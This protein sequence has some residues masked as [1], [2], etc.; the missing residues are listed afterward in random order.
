M[1][2]RGQCAR[3]A[4]QMNYEEGENVLLRCLSHLVFDIYYALSYWIDGG[5][6]VLGEAKSPKVFDE[7]VGELMRQMGDGSPTQLC[8]DS[9]QNQLRRLQAHLGQGSCRCICQSSPVGVMSSLPLDWVS[10][11]RHSA[12]RPLGNRLQRTRLYYCLHS[13]DTRK[14]TI[15]LLAGFILLPST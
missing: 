5:L 13:S 2:L 10:C 4:F 11:G 1:T 14:P 7:L 15:V 6:Y 12:P 3:E 9:M 8:V